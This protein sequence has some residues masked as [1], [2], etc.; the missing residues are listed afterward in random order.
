[1]TRQP[2]LKAWRAFVALAQTHTM[3]AAAQMLG[4][5]PSGVSKAIH[6]LETALGCELIHHNTRPLKLTDAG[7]F[8]LKRMATI[9]QDY[10]EMIEKLANDKKTLDGRIR[11]STAPGFATSL[12][13]PLL[14][15]FTE[16]HPGVTIDIMT[17]ASQEVVARGCCDVAALT[18]RPGMNGLVYMS[19]G[20]NVYVA[21]AS[22]TYI[23]KNGL[24]VTPSDL[25]KHTGYIYSGPVRG[26][27]N[28]LIRNERSEPVVFKRCIRST[29]V[30]A[31][32]SAVTNGMG[33]SIDMPLIQVVD[34]LK[35]GKLVPILPGW[36]R[37]PVEC[38]VV[39]NREAWHQKR[40]RVF[41]H[42]YAKMAQQLFIR[43]EKAVSTI[44]GLPTDCPEVDRAQVYTTDQQQHP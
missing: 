4:T 13:I 40:V 7:K 31:I 37:P 33:V 16:L 20:R 23:A 19:R 18:G 41:M 6:G 2:D 28:V 9:L 3:T 35:D 11:L 42:W 14:R 12:L 24:P 32:R 22:P 36:S 21:V 43:H 29:D 8:A 1:M 15:Q 26:E 27:T 10:D 44:I 17:G 39:T 25:R 30:L 38:F 5:D 34:D